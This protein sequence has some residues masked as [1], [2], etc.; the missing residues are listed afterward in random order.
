MYLYFFRHRPFDYM[1]G[2]S[3]L[4]AT[5]GLCV[6]CACAVVVVVV[7]GPVH[8]NMVL[9]AMQRMLCALPCAKDWS[10]IALA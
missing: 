9:L 10:Y 3:G 8:Y 1:C 4:C 5:V 2:F 6:R 7:A